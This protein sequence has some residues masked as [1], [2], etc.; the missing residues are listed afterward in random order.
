M[1]KVTTSGEP[2][3]KKDKQSAIEKRLQKMEIRFDA[4]EEFVVIDMGSGLT[5]VGFSGEDLPRIVMPTVLGEKTVEV[6]S[7]ANN[8]IGG[9]ELKKMK[10][11]KYGN[12]AY[13][14]MKDDVNKDGYDLHFP[15]QRGIVVDINHA[16]NL[17][18]NVFEQMNLDSKFIN[19]LMTDSP[20]TTKKSK[21]DMAEL[22]FE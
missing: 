1:K 22:M 17:L 5:K 10:D 13:A 18:K 15:V 7:S 3:K 4:G 21:Q 9:G 16:E 12:D 8:A 20:F 14:N 11:I 6:D 19:V 2:E